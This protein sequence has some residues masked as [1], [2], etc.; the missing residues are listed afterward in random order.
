MRDGGS[1]LDVVRLG[2][3]VQASLDAFL[4][5][6]A[7][8]MAEASPELLPLVDAVAAF[9]AGGK[10]LRP[11][12]CYWGWRGAGADDSDAAVAAAASLELFQAAALIH[13]D[14]MD[15]SDSRRGQPSIHRRFAALHDASG[16]SGPSESFGRAGAILLGD[17]TLV[18]NDEML[19]RSGLPVEALLRARPTYDLM[20]TQ[21][22]GGQY[23]DVLEQ[24]RGEG[25]VESARQVIRFKSAKYSVEHPLLI[26]GLLADASPE[27]LAAYSAYGLP[28]GEAF[29]LRDDVLGVFGDPSATGKPAGD[30]LREGKR[31]VLVAHTFAKASPAQAEVM[32]R[33]GDRSLVEADVEAMREV[34]VETGALAAVE[35]TID[36]LVDEAREA[37]AMADIEPVARDVLDALVDAATVRTT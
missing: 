6:Q 34:I 12:F 32:A 9:L 13:D 24:A 30:D 23:L 1:V 29:Q 16:W 28:L 14:V 37:L 21:L 25:T 33:L 36:E 19:M 2:D 11:A 18:W 20:R 27:L 22:M 4:R 10:R 26:G 3:R 7:D 5:T 17:L 15:D 35:Q 31:T 8:L